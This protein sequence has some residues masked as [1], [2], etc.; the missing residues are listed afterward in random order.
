MWSQRFPG[1]GSRCHLHTPKVSL[2]P[3]V[4]WLPVAA[5]VDRGMKCP[6]PVIQQPQCSPMHMSPLSQTYYLNHWKTVFTF[7]AKNHGEYPGPT[8]YSFCYTANHFL[9]FVVNISQLKWGE[10]ARGRTT[11]SARTQATASSFLFSEED[12]CLGSAS[13]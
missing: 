7:L 4:W 9:P 10:T 2:L 5:N 11:F 6:C 8:T 1:R 13:G 12:Q 3:R